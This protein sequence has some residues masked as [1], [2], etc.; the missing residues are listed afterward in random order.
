MRVICEAFEQSPLSHRWKAIYAQMALLPSLLIHRPKI[1]NRH[2][3]TSINLSKRL[4]RAQHKAQEN[5]KSIFTVERPR[6]T[7][8]ILKN[9][10][11]IVELCESNAP[12]DFNVV[13]VPLSS[14]KLRICCMNG[15]W[16]VFGRVFIPLAQPFV[17]RNS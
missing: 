8:T 17:K 11:A 2:F 7:R 5:L 14:L 3:N 9:K 13:H 12:S 15:I 10:A 1:T 16:R 4:R 6:Y